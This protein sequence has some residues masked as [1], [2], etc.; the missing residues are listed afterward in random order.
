[1]R[2]IYQKYLNN[3][4][5]CHHLA[6]ANRFSPDESDEAVLRKITGNA[7]ASYRL[8]LENDA[9]LDEILYS[10]T[11]ADL[12]EEEVRELEEFADLLFTLFRQNDI[13]TSYK[14]HQLLY[15][16]AELKHDRNLRIRELYHMGIGLYFIS[17][18]MSELSVNPGGKQAAEYLLEGAKHLADLEEIE[19][20]NT[21]L[22]VVRCFTNI[23]LS[24]E[25]INGVHRPCEP[26]DR[27]TGYGAFKKRFEEI[28]A[29][30]TSPRYRALAPG[31]NWDA[32]IHNLHFNR[33]MYYF[34]IQSHDCPDIVQDVLESAEYIYRHRD[35]D[36]AQAI[37]EDR[38]DY[39]YAAARWKAGLI[40]ITELVDVLLST[41]SH[42]KKDDYSASGITLNLQMPLC[43][44][45]TFKLMPPQQRE[46]YEPRVRQYTDGIDDYLKNAPL[47]EYSR[48]ITQIVS[49]TIVHRAQQHE[50]LHKRLFDYLL[51]CHAPTYIHVRMAAS[52][53]RKLFLRMIDTGSKELIGV[54]GITDMDEILSRREELADRIYNCSLYHDIG[55]VM[56]LNYV[57]IY[58]RKLL[59]EEFAA[60][61]L[62]SSLGSYLL[63]NFESEELSFAALYHHRFYD[64][65]G[66]Y[67]LNV[68]PCPPEYKLVADI[69]SISDSIEA[70]T[71][72]IGRCY[73]AAKSFDTI[74]HELRQG[75]GKRYAPHVV[76]LFDDEAFYKNL[77]EELH[78]ERRR[79]YLEIYRDKQ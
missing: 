78:G 10:R 32:A 43:L 20:E 68:S 66:G 22:H 79:T 14:I 77:E 52:L 18:I 16:Y 11:A 58:S 2:D 38:I 46:I 21:R 40:D 69:V 13:G 73:S 9:I 29:V 75:S 5:E 19:D 50:P 1:M 45:Y 51:F 4:E 7:A 30:L 3:L 70:A 15:E 57:G 23:Y 56:L 49:D 48:M 67:P 59:D 34:Y 27:F 28:M 36:Y 25:S 63:R 37:K 8:R 31:F 54:F 24:E 47:N 26:Y 39:I 72:D 61:Q 12:T 35:K 64:N 41:L 71:D 44:E 6:R 33:A 17:P 65:S 42:A 55:K 62:H 74:I 53:S 60:I 76:A